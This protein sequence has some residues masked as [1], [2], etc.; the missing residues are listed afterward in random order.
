MSMGADNPAEV[1]DMC[2]GHGADNMTYVAKTGWRD[3]TLAQQCLLN[4]FPPTHTHC[5]PRP[6]SKCWQ[7]SSKQGIFFPFTLFQVRD[8]KGPTFF[9]AMI[10]NIIENA[11]AI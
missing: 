6:Q 8:Q 10:H 4:E 5:I 1:Q 2:C 9:R 11:G 3:E 7:T